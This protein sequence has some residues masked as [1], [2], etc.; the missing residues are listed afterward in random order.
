MVFQAI[1]CVYIC[2][3]I[4]VDPTRGVLNHAHVHVH[5]VGKG[6]LCGGKGSISP[7]RPVPWD[8]GLGN[9]HPYP[10]MTSHG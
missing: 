1:V 7:G 4:H 9:M 2:S 10:L 3:C 6:Q 8:S 5:V